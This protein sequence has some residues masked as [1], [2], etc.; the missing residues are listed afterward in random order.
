[1]ARPKRSR[2]MRDISPTHPNAAAIDIG[3][4]MHVAA[5]PPDRDADPVR[6][7]GTFTGDLHRMADWFESC[8]VRAVATESTGVYWIPAF[9]VLDQRGF[10][11]V[12]V[13]AR[14]AKHVPGRKTD[15]SDAQWLRQLHEY[16]L[17]RAS[18]RPKGELATLRLPAPTRTV[19]GLC[20]LAHSA[21]AKGPDA[22][23]RPVAPHRVRRVRQGC[24]HSR[25]CGGRA[26]SGGTRCASRPP[27]PR[28]SRGDQRCSGRQLA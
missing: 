7:F 20:R 17:L 23:E 13:N 22:D 8:G 9:E 28:V 26:R 1:M 5:V 14:D 4:K 3:A 10:E 2:P 11:V 21:H 27:L 19:A 24:A 15:V 12:L 18:F 25:H 6:T 16:G